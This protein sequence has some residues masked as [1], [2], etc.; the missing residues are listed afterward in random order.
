MRRR[1]EG[2]WPVRA[3]LNVGQQRPDVRRVCD[4]I[5]YR[6]FFEYQT[7]GTSVTTSPN[8]TVVEILKLNA[9]TL[10]E[11]NRTLSIHVSYALHQAECNV[12]AEKIARMIY[13]IL[14]RIRH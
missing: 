1:P 9:N 8:I 13:R 10:S 11:I 3:T 2:D 14:H 12:N 5:D 7:L 4:V 6:V